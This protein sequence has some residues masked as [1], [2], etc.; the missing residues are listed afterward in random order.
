MVAVTISMTAL[1]SKRQELLLTLNELITVMR[2]YT[3]FLDARIRMKGGDSLVMTLIEEW[4]TPEAL[5][6]YMQ[7]EYFR[8][9]HG[10]LQLLTTSA[11]VTICPV[12][13]AHQI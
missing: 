11:E 3:G 4:E 10:A 1:P 13:D 2:R 6:A 7:S 5:H 12:Q 9:L 8:V